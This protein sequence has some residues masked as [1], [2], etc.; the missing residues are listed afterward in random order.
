[1]M[2]TVTPRCLHDDGWSSQG[3]PFVGRHV[4]VS[5]DH[6]T[7]DGEVVIRRDRR[8]KVNRQDGHPWITDALGRLREPILIGWTTFS[9]E[10]EP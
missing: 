9:V 6:V 3:Q 5:K 7:L 2:I 1:M 4:V 8:A 10:V